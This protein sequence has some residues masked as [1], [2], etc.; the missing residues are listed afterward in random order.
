MAGSP[1]PQ[2]S[3][4]WLDL[5]DMLLM[6]K[7]WGHEAGNALLKQIGSELR[8]L[9]NGNTVIRFG[10]DEFVVLL[11]DAGLGEAAGLAGAIMERVAGLGSVWPI[12]GGTPGAGATV[13]AHRWG[14][15]P[16]AALREADLEQMLFKQARKASR[17]TPVR[18][19]LRAGLPLEEYVELLESRLILELGYPRSWTRMAFIER[20]L[21]PAT[22][23]EWQP[24]S[25]VAAAEFEPRFQEIVRSTDRCWINLVAVTV[26][27]DTLI[28]AVEWFPAGPGA[29]PPEDVALMFM[30]EFGFGDGRGDR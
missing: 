22:R 19:P 5:D 25:E 11:P 30:T 29:R 9:A 2:G 4:L 13:A 10:G 14:D 26:A 15:A 28:C 27:A 21:G 24:G 7:T 20:Q 18:P 1:P 17:Q 16:E 3:F 12:E 8:S 23:W 6:N